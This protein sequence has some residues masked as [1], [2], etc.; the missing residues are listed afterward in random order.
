MRVTTT[1]RTHRCQQPA[2][3]TISTILRTTRPRLVARWVQDETGMR[4]E[5]ISD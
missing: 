5:W 1:N 4:C 2:S 3:T